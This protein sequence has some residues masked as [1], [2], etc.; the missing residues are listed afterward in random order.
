MASQNKPLNRNRKSKTSDS[1]LKYSGLALQ[2]VVTIGLMAFL[3]YKIDIWFNLKFPVF[4]MIFIFTGLAG[5]IY[6]LIRLL[7]DN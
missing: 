7:Q 4:L 6:R 2:M 3:G 5:S 1:Y